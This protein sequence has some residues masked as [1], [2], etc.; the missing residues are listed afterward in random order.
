MNLKLAFFYILAVNRILIVALWPSGISK[1]AN[2][3]TY[4]V[5]LNTEFL[6]L[7]RLVSLAPRPTFTFTVSVEANCLHHIVAF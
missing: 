5:T 1:N 3:L 6:M 4:N 7:I 2:K